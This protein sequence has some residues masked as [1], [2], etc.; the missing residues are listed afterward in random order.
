MACA[1]PSDHIKTKERVMQEHEAKLGKLETYATQSAD[2]IRE[3]L[4]RVQNSIKE[5]NAIMVRSQAL[6]ARYKEI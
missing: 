6:A 4:Q 3:K 1:L 2:E 5:Q